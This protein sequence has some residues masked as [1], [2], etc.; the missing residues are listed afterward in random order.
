[1][2]IILLKKVNNLGDFGSLVKVKD[3][4]AR[5]Y[6]IPQGMALLANKANLEVF[7]ARKVELATH[8]EEH[9][10]AAE[11]TR[12]AIEDK[13]IR[14]QAKTA[15]EEGKLYGSVGSH[16]IV[17]KMAKELG[18][19]LERRQIRLPKGNLRMTGEYQVPVHLHVGVDTT[20]KVII[21]AK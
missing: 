8:A 18:V 9:M 15:D 12:S 16:D 20:I 1:M 6:L 3:G 13:S 2:E 5:N 7:E 11:A 21:E 4:Y 14:I 17:E 19:T 10:K